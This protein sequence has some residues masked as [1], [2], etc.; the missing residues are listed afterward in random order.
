MAVVDFEALLRV[1]GVAARLVWQG[2]GLLDEV[3][4]LARVFQSS[5]LGLGAAVVVGVAEGFAGVGPC[6]SAV[7][8]GGVRV[9]GGW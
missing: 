3:A 4:Q 7:G 8:R 1:R 5:C 6:R 9:V 2:E